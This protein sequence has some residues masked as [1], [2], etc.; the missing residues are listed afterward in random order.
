[1]IRA[2]LLVSLV[3]ISSVSIHSVD[4]LAQSSSG[5]SSSGCKERLLTFPAWYRG[6]VDGNCELKLP[7]ADGDDTSSLSEFI[8]RIALNIVEIMLNLVGYAAVG[9]IIYGGY[10]YMISAGSADG[11]V[12][13]R[14]TIMNA[15]IGLI[16]SIMSIGIVNVIAQGL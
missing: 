8:W 10:R 6:V 11:M 2:L 5:Q 12:A 3:S 13:A 9:F 16:I 14:K 1:M 15:V 4:T 7:K